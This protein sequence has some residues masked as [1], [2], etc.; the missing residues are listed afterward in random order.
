MTIEGYNADMKGI[1]KYETNLKPTA[2]GAAI[3]VLPKGGYIY[4]TLGA[5]DLTGFSYYYTSNGVKVELGTT[6][7]AWSANLILTDEAEPTAPPVD[8]PIDPPVAIGAIYHWR[9]SVDGGKTFDDG[10]YLEVIE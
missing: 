7:K 5:T 10:I 1:A 3:A 6:C 4:G 8:P 2:G 9:K